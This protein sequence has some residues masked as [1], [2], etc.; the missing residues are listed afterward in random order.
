MDK[1]TTYLAAAAAVLVLAVVAYFAMR[2]RREPATPANGS[3][4]G[5]APA[6]KKPSPP[7][8]SKPST[9]PRER[10]PE[11][12][13][14]DVGT[15]GVAYPGSRRGDGSLAFAGDIT[16]RL[17]ATIATAAQLRAAYR[18]GA[19]WCHS[20]WTAD[21]SGFASLFP[22]Q[23]PAPGCGTKPGL[24]DG[25]RTPDVGAGLHLFGVKPAE[26]TLPMC[27]G[28]VE[29]GTLCILPW[30]SDTYHDPASLGR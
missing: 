7:P 14:V 5:G 24:N 15:Y 20:G 19:N 22:I 25:G 2:R 6:A 21:G 28:K 26:G 1:K 13:L 27:S 10:K 8:S 3:P 30:N 4:A 29:S 17:G 23:V 18:G 11:V 12:Y 9:P 16:G